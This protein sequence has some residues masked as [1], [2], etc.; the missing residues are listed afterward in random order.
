NFSRSHEHAT[1][2][3]TCTRHSNDA[4]VPAPYLTR[5]DAQSY[6]ETYARTFM[7]GPLPTL[8]RRSAHRAANGEFHC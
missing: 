7:D 5:P 1:H 4:A 8:N 2:R 6:A 3:S